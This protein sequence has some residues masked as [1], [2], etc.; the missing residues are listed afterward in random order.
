[1]KSKEVKPYGLN[2]NLLRKAVAEKGLRIRTALYDH[3]HFLDY[4]CMTS[5]LELSES[6]DLTSLVPSM[7]MLVSLTCQ[8]A[9]NLW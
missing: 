5:R 1:V 3:L 7:L 2:E 9:A 4:S 8:V 6:L